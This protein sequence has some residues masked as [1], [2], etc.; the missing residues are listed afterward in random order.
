M[1]VS[2]EIYD[3][4]WPYLEANPVTATEAGF[5]ALAR[6]AGYAAADIARVGGAVYDELLLRLV[7]RVRSFEA[8]RAAFAGATAAQRLRVIRDVR[9]VLAGGPFRAEEA[10][11]RL[12]LVVAALAVVDR[13]LANNATAR[14]AV[15][16]AFPSP[17]PVRDDALAVW[18]LGVAAVQARRAAL[19]R[20]QEELLA[21][22]SG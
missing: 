14:A 9:A 15:L 20:S 22:G 19:L 6:G 3:L 4:V 18:D 7:I 13:Q 12:A 21:E 10:S 16:A 5:V 8:V 17:G 11:S 2:L 1:G